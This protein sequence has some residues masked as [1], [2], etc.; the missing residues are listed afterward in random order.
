MSQKKKNV[1]EKSETVWLCGISWPILPHREISWRNE[2][3]VGYHGMDTSELWHNLCTLEGRWMWPKSMFVR[4]NILWGINGVVWG[5]YNS[6][7]PWT[8]FVWGELTSEQVRIWPR[9]TRHGGKDRKWEEASSD[10]LHFLQHNHPLTICTF[11]QCNEVWRNTYISCFDF[12]F[13]IWL[14]F[15]GQLLIVVLVTQ[16]EY[17]W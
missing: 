10:L 2:S 8:I 13:W 17:D 15:C 16:I 9:E 4:T 1:N 14:R 12:I 5:P 6:K 3:Q 7:D 11:L